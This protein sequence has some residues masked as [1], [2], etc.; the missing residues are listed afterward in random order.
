VIVLQQQMDKH[1]KMVEL[2]VA[3]QDL[4]NVTV[5]LDFLDQIVKLQMLVLMVQMDNSVR[6]EA[7]QLEQQ[8]IVAAHVHQLILETTVRLLLLVLWDQI[9]HLVRTLEL[10]Q[11]L[12]LQ[13]IAHANVSMAI[14]EKFVKIHLVVQLGQMVNL[15]LMMVHQQEHKETVDVNVLELGKVLIVNK[16]LLVK[17]VPTIYHAKIKVLQLVIFLQDA[18]AVAQANFLEI[19]A[20]LQ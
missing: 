4:V 20:R 6:M 10:Q 16:Q 8:V 19:I 18:H 14:L 1:A 9:K 17:Q 15:V 13:M 3:K 11:A 2:L 12:F 5:Y 7:N